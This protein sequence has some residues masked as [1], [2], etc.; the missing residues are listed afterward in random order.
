M[1][2][3]SPFALEAARTAH[4]TARLALADTSSRAPPPP[5]RA[6]RDRPD[7]ALARWWVIQDR[8]DAL[9]L[10][11]LQVQRAYRVAQQLQDSKRSVT[12][13]IASGMSL[14][15]SCLLDGEPHPVL[16]GGLGDQAHALQ[17][18]C[19]VYGVRCLST[20]AEAR[21][22]ATLCQL[23]WVDVAQV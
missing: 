13:G 23:Q 22:L 5:P 7:K 9:P 19:Q 10:L 18:L 8:H 14:V 6:V 11:P 15:G 17:R 16:T 21:E 3:T 12:C 2:L 4:P 20:S 1:T